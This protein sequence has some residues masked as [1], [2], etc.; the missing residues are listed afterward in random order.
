MKKIIIILFLINNIVALAQNYINISFSGEYTINN[1]CSDSIINKNYYLSLLDN[2]QYNLFVKGTEEDSEVEEIFYED[3]NT[4]IKLRSHDMILLRDPDFSGNYFVKN[5]TITLNG[6]NGNIL[7]LFKIIDTLNFQ[8]ILLYDKHLKNCYFNRESAYFNCP[9]IPY[10]WLII[11]EI[12]NNTKCYRKIS[13]SS[14]Q[15]NIYD[16]ETKE[17]LPLDIYK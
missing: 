15:K 13:V 3:Q 2:Y 11:P 8:V 5:D 17:Y 7:G 9:S 10:K 16:Y 14:P 1:F 6:K 4:G 12:I